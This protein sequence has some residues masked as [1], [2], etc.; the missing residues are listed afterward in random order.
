MTSDVDKAPTTLLTDDIYNETEWGYGIRSPEKAFKWFKLLLL[1]DGDVPE[2]LKASEQLI[3]A[4]QTLLSSGHD[5]V[6]VVACYLRH[7]WCHALRCIE[8]EKGVAEVDKC[9]FRIVLTVPAIWPPYATNRTRKAAEIAGMLDHR[10]GGETI[11]DFISEPE[12]AA[13]ATIG[14]MDKRSDIKVMKLE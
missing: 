14:D 3:K 1:N 12:A 2:E 8:R 7:L 4:K 9:R 6:Y 13:V 5:A 10:W 11:L